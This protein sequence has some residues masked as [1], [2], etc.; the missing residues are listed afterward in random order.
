[1][2]LKTLF[3]SPPSNAELASAQEA[4]HASW[5]EASDDVAE[6]YRNWDAAPRVERFLAHAAYLA[7]L[8]REEHAA[9][10]YQ[11]VV[12]QRRGGADGR[13]SW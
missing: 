8:E 12:E 7:S 6:A 11:E 5:R 3:R 10:A 1:M 9:S 4:C 13:V 2:Q